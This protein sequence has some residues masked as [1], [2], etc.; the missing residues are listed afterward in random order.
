MY[1]VGVLQT[2]LQTHV[3]HR[4][5]TFQAFNYGAHQARAACC[6]LPLSRRRQAHAFLPE[7][8]DIKASYKSSIRR[9]MRALENLFTTYVRAF[10]VSSRYR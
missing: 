5:P 10:S 4:Q 6:G 1:K 3:R 8:W 2:D 9:A 7:S